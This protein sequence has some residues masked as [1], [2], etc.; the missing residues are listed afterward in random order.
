[1]DKSFKSTFKKVGD[2]VLPKFSGKRIMMMPLILGDPKS[3]PDFLEEWKETIAQLA[4]LGAHP[5]EIGYLTIDEKIVK[6]E[7]THRRQGAHVD[8]AYHGSFGV[9]GGGSGG[10]WG[11]LGNGMLTVSSHPGCKA[12]NQ[13]FIGNVGLEGEADHLLSQA[14]EECS[15]TFGANEVFWVDGACVHMSLPMKE[16]TPRQFVRLSLPSKAPWFEGYTENPLG[17]SPSG[18]ILSRRTFLDN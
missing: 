1:M 15:V 16:T 9:W 17:V 14:H 18:P 3:I 6:K 8:G 4:A 12:W 7:E 5:G 2:L 10:G 13:E 11:S